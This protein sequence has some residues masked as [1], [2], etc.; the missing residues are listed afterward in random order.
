[1]ILCF[2]TSGKTSKNY[3][4][5]KISYGYF[6]I[7][8]AHVFEDI[9]FLYFPQGQILSLAEFQKYPHLIDLLLEIVGFSDTDDLFY[10]V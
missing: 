5:N 4:H 7:S 6:Q 9:K 1:M 3:C 8:L 10:E 2:C